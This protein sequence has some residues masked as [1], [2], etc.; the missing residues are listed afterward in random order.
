MAYKDHFSQAAADYAAYR[1]RYPDSLFAALA[2]HAPGRSL[3]WD[4]ATGNGQAAVSLAAHFERV[5]ATDASAAQLARA[6]PHAAIEYRVATAEESGLPAGVADLITVAQAAHWLD[7][8][9][10]YA[11]ARRVAVRDGVVALWGYPLMSVDGEIDPE[12]RRYAHAVCGPY[13]P[14]ER[15]LIDDEYRTIAFPFEPLEMPRL[16]IAAHLTL[17]QFVGYLRSWSATRGL[18]AARGTHAFDDAMAPIASAWGDPERARS[19]TWPLA[20]RAGRIHASRP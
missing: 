12:L 13:W 16:E 9:R 3:A 2:A 10:F 11:E 8:E 15:R 1:P 4:C 5:I 19:V 6:T 14:P 7:L 20:V 17:A 18:I